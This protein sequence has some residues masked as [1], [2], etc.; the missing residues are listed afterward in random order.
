MDVITI[1]FLEKEEDIFE[2]TY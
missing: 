1:M 2:Y